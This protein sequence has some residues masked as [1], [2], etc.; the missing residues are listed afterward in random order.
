M[1]QV[2]EQPHIN[3]W[4]VSL[5]ISISIISLFKI[6]HCV[7]DFILRRLNVERLFQAPTVQ[8]AKTHTPIPRCSRKGRHPQ[9]AHASTLQGFIYEQLHFIMSEDKVQ[10]L[11]QLKVTW[12]KKQ[13]PHLGQSQLL[14]P[15]S[16]TTHKST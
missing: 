9:K 8:L 15:Y 4:H 7:S 14:T 11:Q 2:H 3:L 12:G 5:Q 10:I 16:L 1:M 6:F 13:Q